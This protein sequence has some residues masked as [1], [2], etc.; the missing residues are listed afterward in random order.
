MMPSAK[1]AMR[2]M[3]PPASMLNTSSRPP[4]CCCNCMRECS[5]VDARHRDISAEPRHD[6]GDQ[7]EQNPL[8]ELG[9]LAEGGKIEI[10]CQL[11][12]C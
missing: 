12:G 7:R 10:C 3:A 6:Q 8:L 11:F 5:R 1:I 4:C 2:L 9:R